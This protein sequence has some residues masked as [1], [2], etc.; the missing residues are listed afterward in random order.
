MQGRYLDRAVGACVG[1]YGLDP[2][3]AVYY[4]CMV[5]DNELPSTAKMAPNTCST[6]RLMSCQM[7]EQE[8]SGLSPCTT[9][10]TICL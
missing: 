8:G 9:C 7:F 3:E 4:R 2:E 6:L 1:L 5:D 10:P